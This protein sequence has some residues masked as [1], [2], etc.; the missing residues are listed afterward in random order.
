MSV[1]D[2][3]P[4]SSNTPPEGSL[5]RWA[6]DYVLSDSLQYKL[7]PPPL[8]AA[9][10]TPCAALRIAQP[11]RPPELRVST[12]KAKPPRAG[13]LREPSKRAELLH[14]FLHHELQAAE[15]MCWAV[16]AFPDTPASFKR[17]LIA[18]CHDEIRHMRMY[19]AEIERLGCA[20]GEFPVR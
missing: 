17:G 2:P 4:S 3:R 6:Y 13:A 15:L 9:S 16:L 18:I 20:V 14:T 12:D 11:G 8:P 7:A 5:E 19:A 1:P 10:P